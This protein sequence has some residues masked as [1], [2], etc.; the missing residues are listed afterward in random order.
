ML[1]H[2]AILYN[3]TWKYDAIWSA[4]QNSSASVVLHKIILSSLFVSVH[5]DWTALDSS[6]YDRCRSAIYQAPFNRNMPKW[7]IQPVDSYRIPLEL[8]LP[9]A[10]FLRNSS[11]AISWFKIAAMYTGQ[12]QIMQG[13]QV[14]FLKKHH[15][16]PWC[17]RK[18]LRY[19]LARNI[20][21]QRLEKAQKCLEEN[22]SYVEFPF[23]RELHGNSCSDWQLPLI[24]AHTVHKSCFALVKHW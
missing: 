11:K 13:Q 15:G 4:S 2:L 17:K 8:N 3:A 7:S 1:C 19:K 23:W 16:T 21:K 18:S 14:L 5:A 22:F 10:E 9:N 24:K 12:P 20:T 6:S